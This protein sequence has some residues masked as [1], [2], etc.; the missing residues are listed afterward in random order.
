MNRRV[1]ARPATLRT[2]FMSRTTIV[3]GLGRAGGA[4]RVRP[5]EFGVRAG[6][7]GLPSSSDRK[8][9][10]PAGVEVIDSARA[11]GTIGI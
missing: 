5:T 8:K 3:H 10:R 6:P 2:P 1:I 7:R 11:R 4:S 9:G